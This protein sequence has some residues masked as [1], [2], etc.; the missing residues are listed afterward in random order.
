MACRR[1]RTLFDVVGTI[2]ALDT[3]YDRRRAKRLV[4]DAF[5]RGFVPSK[6]Y[7]GRWNSLLSEACILD[8][9]SSWKQIVAIGGRDAVGRALQATKPNHAALGSILLLNL[10]DLEVV[11]PVM[12]ALRETA[13][14]DGT[15]NMDGLL[16]ASIM[17]AVNTGNADVLRYLLQC[18]TD[19]P[20]NPSAAF[21]LCIVTKHTDVMR[22][23][24]EMQG[25]GGLS[26][27]SA[28]DVSRGLSMAAEDG[29]TEIVDMLLL[30]PMI[31][32]VAPVSLR[33]ALAD[34]VRHGHA[35]VVRRMLAMPN[36]QELFN[37]TCL[38]MSWRNAWTGMHT[39]VCEVFEGH[40]LMLPLKD[41]LSL[42]VFHNCGSLVEKMLA[43]SPAAA[44]A[45]VASA[46]LSLMLEIACRDAFEGV[47][48]ALLRH[49]EFGRAPL[50]KAMNA[51]GTSRI[52]R[53]LLE[54]IAAL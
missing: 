13:A 40:L 27:L 51:A 11:T 30:L 20:K 32:E 6:E 39:A 7:E 35:E 8:P 16:T 42:A 23:I 1:L 52:K 33:M 12:L 44:A 41:V 4:L 53:M 22:A 28:A 19:G 29:S 38:V 46:R 26:A 43:A 50:D 3:P 37:L 18:P 47:V 10:D 17:K 21:L 48:E 2:I 34:A 25:T 31:Q 15:N 14:A 5:A 36:S 9:L 24:I 54:H 49:A 45:P